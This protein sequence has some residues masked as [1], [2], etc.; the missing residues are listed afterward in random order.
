[1][2]IYTEKIIVGIKVN[3]FGPTLRL[4]DAWV[5]T[6]ED[7]YNQLEKGKGYL[8][9]IHMDDKGKKKITKI[10]ETQQVQETKK[11][12]YEK[13]VEASAKGEFRT[14]D[15][16]MRSSAIGVALSFVAQAL[17]NDLQTEFDIKVNYAFN[18]AKEVEKY[19]QGE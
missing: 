12:A 13:K 14:P 6:T 2:K 4:G 15:Q 10:V 8:V 7:L 11:P 17:Q 9:E 1:M 19:I 3:K 18:L 5:S 16:I